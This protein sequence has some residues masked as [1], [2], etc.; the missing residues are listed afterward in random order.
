MTGRFSCAR[1][2][3]SRDEPLYATA[4][5]VRRWILVEEPG[6]WG[7]EALAD[8]RLP[9]VVAEGLRVRAG[10]VGA[11]LL[12][13][14]RHGRYTPAA[15]TC[16]VAST[17]Q[18]GAWL[19]RIAFADAAELLDVDWGPL[20]DHR[21]VG[22]K[23]L[24]T[25]ALLVCTN[26][27]H[28]TCCAEF[29]R[30]VA[31]VLAPAFPGQVWESSHFGGDRFAANLV[32]LPHGL[33]FGRLSPADAARVVADYHHDHIALAHFRGHCYYPFV[34]QAAE[35]HLRAAAGLTGLADLH[36]AG[37][38]PVADTTSRVVF[39]LRDGRRAT[40]VVEARTGGAPRRLTCDGRPSVAPTYRL[41]DLR[42]DGSA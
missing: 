37:A 13:V 21:S 38:T 1:D 18:D 24:D 29:G 17:T 10:Q 16:L 20:G 6:P 31:E 8:S 42:V 22:G 14:R 12:L 19:E 32:C 25:P 39:D 2:S 34:V 41:H 40:V 33:Y 35:H 36:L 15:R 5:T 4:S 30:P 26:G 9:D 28:D 7:R 23:P 27:R 11:R 3:R